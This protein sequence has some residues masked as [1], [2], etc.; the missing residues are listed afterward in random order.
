M[1]QV[2]KLQNQYLHNSTGDGTLPQAIPGGTGTRPKAAGGAHDKKESEVAQIL[3][4]FCYSWFRLQLMAIHCNRRVCRQI[5]LT[6]HFLSCTVRTL[7]DVHSH[8]GSRMCLCASPHTHGHP[9]RAVECSFFDSLFLALFLSVCLSYPLF[10]SFH[11]YLYSVLNFFFHVDNA[12]AI[13]HW[14]SAK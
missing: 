8:H 1:N 10:F 14:H 5:H 9:C 6:R 2:K 12:K 7:N 4:L 3:S 13:N 11:F